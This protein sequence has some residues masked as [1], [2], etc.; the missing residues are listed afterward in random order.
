MKSFVIFNKEKINYK[1]AKNRESARNSRKRKKMYFE[2]LESKVVEL[3]DELK[4][5][6]NKIKDLE[7]NQD[8]LFYHSRIVIYIHF[9]NA[10][11]KNSLTGF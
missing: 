11:N 4:E 9:S 1:L 2:M 5:A 10:Q 7:E 6:K 3:S 8:K